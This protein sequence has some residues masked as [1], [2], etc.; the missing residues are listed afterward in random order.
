MNPSQ[1]RPSGGEPRYLEELKVQLG[2]QLNE[3]V[4]FIF[5]KVSLYNQS[6]LTIHVETDPFADCRWDAVVGEA[7]VDA[8]IEAAYVA[9]LQVGTVVCF[10]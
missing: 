8:G 7:E 4:N 9:E 1:S 6:S 3:Q 10:H 5:I 2:F